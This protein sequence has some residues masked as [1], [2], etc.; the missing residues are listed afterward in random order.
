MIPSLPFFRTFLRGLVLRVAPALIFASAGVSSWAAEAVPARQ[1]FAVE[2]GDAVRTLKLFSAQA[3]EQIVYPVE[4]VRGVRTKA[5]TGEFT[6][7]EALNRMLEDTDLMVVQDESTG[8]LT[9]KRKPGR[10]KDDKRAEER[11]VLELD[12]YS[13][14]GA[15]PPVFSDRNADLPRG[16]NDAQPYYVF[17]A[18]AIDQS[19]AV[20]IEDFLKQRLTMNTVAETSGQTFVSPFLGNV[21][22]INLRGLGADKTLILVNGR[23]VPGVQVGV[24]EYQPDLNGIPLGAIERIEVLPSSASG[25]YGGG[26]IGGVV[27][28]ILKKEYAGGEVKTTYENTWDS[29]APIRTVAAT[30]GQA[31]EGGRT[32]FLVTATLADASPLLQQDRMGLFTR[33][34]TRILANSPDL[35]YSSTSPFLGSTPNITRNTNGNLTL[36][37]GV[38]L[39]SRITSVPA[40]TSP[41]TPAATLAAGLLQRAGSYN[42]EP[43]RSTQFGG[44]L[45][46]FGYTPETKSLMASLRRRMTERVEAFAEFSYNANH[47]DTVYNPIGETGFVRVRATAPTSPFQEDVRLSLPAATAAVAASD[48]AS[49]NV[50]VGVIAK[51]PRSWTAMA[52]YAWSENRFD[53]QY[54]ST[55]STSLAADLNS[56][57]LNPFVDTL[58]HPLNLEPYLVPNRYQGSSTLESATLRGSGPF[59]SLPWGVPVLTVGLE[60]RKAA[61][62]DRELVT[63]TPLLPAN[64]QRVLYFARSQ[65]TDSGYAEAEIPLAPRDRWP[66]LHELS[67]Q[68]SG[69]S[70]RYQVDAGTPN[71]FISST[72]GVT[73]GTPN[74]NGQRY[75]TRARYR[76]NNSTAGIKYQPRPDLIL[77]VS[78]ATAFLPPAPAQLVTNPLPN[79]FSS[80]IVDPRTGTSYPVQTLSGGNPGLKPQNSESWNAGLVWE[81]RTG[82][83]DGLRVNIEFYRITQFDKIGSLSAQQ[84]VNAESRYP[85]RVTRNAAGLVTLVDTSLLNL[86]RYETEGWDLS[87]DYQRKTAAG[88]LTLRLGGTRIAAERRQDAV[89]A[90]LLDYAG[91]VA[92]GGPAK[93]KANATLT[94][95]YRHWTAGW[96]ARYFHSYRQYG[97]AGGP[98]SIQFFAGAED[99]FYIQAQ[100]GDTIP[101]QT[102]HDVFLTRTFEQDAERPGRLGARLLDGLRVQVGVKNVLGTLPPYDAYFSYYTSP[103]G[104]VRLRS[105]WMSVRKVF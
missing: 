81:S 9:V 100:G 43:P 104:D 22:S 91:Y 36:D 85:G 20:N 49:R 77:R 18:Q 98:D 97:A 4:R 53:Y 13:V 24:T 38:S 59:F 16:I 60:H 65:S 51:L 19:G 23:R 12:P 76:S 92:E 15:K 56:G 103:Y 10:P 14:T 54:F 101:A 71:A 102:Y 66:L 34:L 55:D 44:L 11:K 28:V 47:S 32:H 82:L 50:T 95:E 72:G 48:S 83:L 17:S 96:T 52:D 29:D 26:A 33:G 87:L 67:L 42:F 31:L 2:A 75:D 80:T 45:R 73:Y 61:T 89:D 1:R 5:V 30:F 93:I 84:I 39:G 21:S 79:S 8:A 6:A 70:E 105:Y 40:G 86:T 63:E 41:S 58:L 74:L 62:P 37:N 64:N 27:N 94:W 88:I 7:R 78:H 99:P 90:P 3:G 69:R 46:P 57:A 68:V 35:L 25:I